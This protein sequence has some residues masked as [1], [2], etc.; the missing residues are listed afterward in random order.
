MKK[1]IQGPFFSQIQ[2]HSDLPVGRFIQD[3]VVLPIRGSIN[4]SL[5]VTYPRSTSVLAKLK[6]NLFAAGEN[7]P[8]EIKQKLFG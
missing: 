8:V 6:Y 2:V 1:E 7:F 5:T 4:E 3:H